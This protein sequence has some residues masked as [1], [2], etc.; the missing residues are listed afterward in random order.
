MGTR[1]TV[2]GEVT[3][4]V[5]LSVNEVDYAYPTLDIKAVTIWQLQVPVWWSRPYPYFGAYWGSYWGPPHW[6]PLQEGKR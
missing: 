2:V 5:T 4:S 1:V 3:G 6:V